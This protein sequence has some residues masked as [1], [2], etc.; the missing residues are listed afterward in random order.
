MLTNLDTPTPPPPIQNAEKISSIRCPVDWL[1]GLT[2]YGPMTQPNL[3]TSTQS[4][5]GW[6]TKP[7]NPLF[8][9]LWNVQRGK[10]QTK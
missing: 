10:V 1:G 7:V 9:I 4:T 5:L 2:R 8:S 6:K 3:I